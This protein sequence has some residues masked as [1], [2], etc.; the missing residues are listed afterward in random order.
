MFSRYHNTMP[1]GIPLE[2]Q[3][4]RF[5]MDTTH[6]ALVALA[7]LVEQPAVSDDLIHIPLPGGGLISTATWPHSV[8]AA[9]FDSAGALRASVFV[10][11]GHL[12]A[13]RKLALQIV[14]IADD[15]PRA[16]LRLLQAEADALRRELGIRASGT[17]IYHEDA[18]PDCRIIVIGDG[19]DGAVMRVVTGAYPVDCATIELRHF[20]TETAARAAAA[21]YGTGRQNN[22]AEEASDLC[23]DCTVG[24]EA[25]EHWAAAGSRMPPH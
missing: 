21:C 20:T 16:R 22:A 5:S 1:R 10:P 17:V 13:A 19:M 23:S 8:S 12:A 9:L 14:A 25:A 15:Y 2:L 3:Y 4:R 18:E 7:A 6:E 11:R 24:A